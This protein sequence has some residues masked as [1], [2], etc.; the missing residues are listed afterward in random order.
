MSEP[1]FEGYEAGRVFP[2]G[3]VAAVGRLM[4]GQGQIVAHSSVA[5]WRYGWRDQ[6]MYERFADAVVAFGQWDGTGEPTGWVRHVPSYRR[7]EGG[8]PNKETV[9]P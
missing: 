8:D 1:D 7:R 6:W 2:D 9:A 3:R 5:E 4:L